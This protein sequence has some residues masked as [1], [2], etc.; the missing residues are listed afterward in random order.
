ML[1]K[2][3][4]F[5]H[6]QSNEDIAYIME[7]FIGIL[8]GQEKAD[9]TSVELYLK[10][11]SGLMMAL[12]RIDYMSHSTGFAKNLLHE[13]IGKRALNLGIVRSKGEG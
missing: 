5:L 9:P 1:T 13:L 7:R 11:M 8:R 10:N 2:C 3:N 6:K 4:E 12:N